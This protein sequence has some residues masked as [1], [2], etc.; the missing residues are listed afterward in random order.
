MSTVVDISVLWVKISVDVLVR[1]FPFFKYS[2]YKLYFCCLKLLIYQNPQS[3]LLG[4]FCPSE[5]FVSSSHDV[6]SA[7]NAHVAK[8]K[9][10]GRRST[11]FPVNKETCVCIA[12]ETDYF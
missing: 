2:L 3:S 11:I 8:I 4:A 10:F 7:S 1:S 5:Y 12:N 9:A 6:E